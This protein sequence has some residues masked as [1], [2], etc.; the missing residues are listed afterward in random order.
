ML[1]VITLESDSANK[2]NLTQNK[3]HRVDD[4]RHRR[5][6]VGR[7]DFVAVGDCGDP[8]QPGVGEVESEQ[9]EGVVGRGRFNQRIDNQAT[10]FQHY[11][12]E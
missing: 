8:G 11:L 1:G 12:K 6:Q 9:S 2:T 10:A 4:C 7:R 5:R 3:L